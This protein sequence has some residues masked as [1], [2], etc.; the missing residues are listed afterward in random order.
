M[1]KSI[2]NPRIYILKRVSFKPWSLDAP[3]EEQ[4]THSKVN[5][6]EQEVKD[7]RKQVVN[8]AQKFNKKAIHA[9]TRD[10]R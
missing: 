1:K 7:I 8:K 4:W 2:G 5:Q 10:S 6:Y 3:K 9:P